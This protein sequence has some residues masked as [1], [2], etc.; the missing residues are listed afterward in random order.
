MRMLSEAQQAPDPLAY[1]LAVMRDPEADPARRDRAAI[2]ALPY[3]H[4]RAEAGGKKAAPAVG[5]FNTPTMTGV[6]TPKRKL[7]RYRDHP[8]WTELFDLAADPF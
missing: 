3:L 6:R 5:G 8:E 4:V 2:A 7:L 1:L